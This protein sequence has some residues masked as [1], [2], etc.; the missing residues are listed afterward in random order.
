MNTREYDRSCTLEGYAQ[1]YA[2][3]LVNPGKLL[4]VAKFQSG[5]RMI[6]LCGGTGLVAKEAI[7]RGAHTAFVVD[8][9]PRLDFED[10][11]ALPSIRGRAE[12]VDLLLRRH[13]RMLHE[14]SG[15]MFDDNYRVVGGDPR[16]RGEGCRCHR[17]APDFDLVVCRQA[18]NY[19]DINDAFRGV[20]QVLRSGGRFVFNTF[21]KPPRAAFKTYTFDRRRF[22]EASIHL[23][24]RVWHLQA[25]RRAYDISKFY[26]QPEDRIDTLL[27]RYF[28]RFDK[29]RSDKGLTYVAWRS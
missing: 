23:R 21:Q 8:L 13:V 29:T 5:E 28:A 26:W 15:L 9:N 24:R 10:G 17:Y 19:L 11:R 1:L 18:I 22:F 14:I 20:A 27:L 12:D 6:D 3:W 7:A 25:S 4:D 16:C 2:R